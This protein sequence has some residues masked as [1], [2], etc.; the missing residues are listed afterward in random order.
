MK[1]N[2]YVKDAFDFWFIP[3]KGL[4][5]MNASQVVTLERI[6]SFLSK[7]AENSLDVYWLSS[8]D[9]SKIQYISPAYEQI[10]QR[11]R[12]ELYGNP[13]CWIT[14]L[15][16]DDAKDDYNPIMAMAH[17]VATLGPEARYNESYRIIRPTGEVRWIVDRG[18]PV[19]DDM[20][21]CC[22]VTG[23]A[24]DVT[25]EK[26]QEELFRVAKDEAEK[27]S[28][29]KSEFI[30]NMEHDIRTPF[31]GIWGMSNILLKREKDE[32]KRE[33]LADIVGASKELLDYCNDILDFSKIESGSLKIVKKPFNLKQLINSISDIEMPAA[34]L[35]QLDFFVKMNEQVPGVLI[36]DEYRLKRILINLVSNSIKFTRKGYVSISIVKHVSNGRDI[37]LDFVVE[38]TGIGI[39]KEKQDLIYEKFSKITPSNSGTDKGRGLGLQIV[40]Q[41][42]EELD[43]D[44]YLK[45]QEGE[46]TSFTIRLPLKIPH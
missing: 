44:L 33:M 26:Q 12:Q 19:Y 3:Y 16:P 41:F 6:G 37:V 20:G 14:F 27:A 22:G 31:S 15:H 13:E 5:H 46:G 25:Q 45:S 7:L 17:K 21:N 23:V 34:K 39:P 2:A 30:Q 18:F 43:A 32:D 28:Q 10:W 42:S 29:L 11:S 40:R 1:D 24:V 35:N 38:D 36:G 4:V 9:F 8:P